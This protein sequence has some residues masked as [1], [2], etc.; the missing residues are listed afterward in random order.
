MAKSEVGCVHQI[1][2]VESNLNFFE[3]TISISEPV[4]EFV[5]KEM[6]IFKH[7]QIV[8]KEIKCPFELWAKH[9][10]MFFIV[11]FLDQQILEIA[12]LQIESNFFFFKARVLI[13]LRRGCL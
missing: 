2:D 5:T 9:E 1:K 7:Y 13:K 10:A 3:Q 8:S 11:S 4:T 12:G 6:L